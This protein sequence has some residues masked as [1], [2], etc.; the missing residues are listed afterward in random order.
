MPKE[1]EYVLV[2]DKTSKVLFSTTDAIEAN[3]TAILLARADAEFT[4]FRAI[5]LKTLAGY[6]SEQVRVQ[7][8]QGKMIEPPG[9]IIESAKIPL[10][11]RPCLEQLRAQYPQNQN[12]KEILA[13][14]RRADD[15]PQEPDFDEEQ[16]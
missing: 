8:A 5:S 1:T 7:N 15:S 12:R 2:S 16:K 11:V 13:P 6:S 14:T 9:G 10:D 3:K 4:V